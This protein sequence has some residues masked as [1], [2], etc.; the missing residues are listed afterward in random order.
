MRTVVYTENKVRYSTCRN[1]EQIG[2]KNAPHSI[3]IPF[4]QSKHHGKGP[5]SKFASHPNQLP[6]EN[7]PT[8][9]EACSIFVESLILKCHCKLTISTNSRLIL[10]NTQSLVFYFASIRFLPC[11]VLVIKHFH[12]CPIHNSKI[13]ITPV[14]IYQPGTYVVFV[15]QICS[16]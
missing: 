7:L 3:T 16:S 8:E 14:Y 9:S 11:S 6:L 12:L 4:Q 13:G 5:S 2:H 15:S 10:T 1:D